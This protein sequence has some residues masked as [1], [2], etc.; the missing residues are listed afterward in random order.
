MKAAVWD[1]I[2]HVSIMEKPMPVADD[3]HV[4]VKVK[5][6]GV[7]ATDIHMITGK[8]ELA[9][10]PHVLGHEI[11]GEIAEIGQ[12]VAG[13]NVGDRVVIDTIVSCGRCTAC[14]SGRKKG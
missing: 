1:K 7:C 14:K 5:A 11:A 4:V 3:G 8:V 6:V 9:T 12:G 13:W 10:P 2:G